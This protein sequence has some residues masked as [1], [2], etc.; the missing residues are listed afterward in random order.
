MYLEHKSS[1]ALALYIKGLSQL[2]AQHL[3]T[4]KE[5]L[6]VLKEI[7]EITNSVSTQF[8][9][10][11]GNLENDTIILTF[12]TSINV[13]HHELKAVEAANVLQGKL[14]KLSEKWNSSIDTELFYN[15]LN[16]R[17]AICND[18]TFCGN[19]GSHDCKNFTSIS[20]LKPHLVSLFAK[21]Q[22]M[23]VQ[24]ILSDSIYKKV[25][26]KFETRCI[27]KVDWLSGKN[28]FSLFPSIDQTNEPPHLT[29]VHELGNSLTIQMDEWLYELEQKEKSSKW[30][31]YNAAIDCF[32]KNEFEKAKQFFE[33]F[34]SKNPQ[35]IPTLHMIRECDLKL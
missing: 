11:R 16:F 20:C 18:N 29:H 17:I 35:D 12:N 26:S 7:F 1:T 25:S 33:E 31:V 6:H 2:F 14:Q 13:N 4:E 24:I 5:I 10:Q 19:V 21:S 8:N 34:L 27:G 30:K 9:A 22:S 3:K 23:N 15:Q 28:E 32:E